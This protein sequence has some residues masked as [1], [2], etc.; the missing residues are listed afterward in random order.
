M[1]DGGRGTILVVD[2]DADDRMLV[3]RALRVVAPDVRVE[4]AVD[5]E[6]A[7]GFLRDGSRPRP[8]LVLLDL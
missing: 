7:L 3:R 6:D 4:E 5:G 8:D 2:D 1:S